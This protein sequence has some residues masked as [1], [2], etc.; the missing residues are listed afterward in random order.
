M[1][2][3]I[4]SWKGSGKGE[5]IVACRREINQFVSS[6]SYSDEL[7]WTD[8][9]VFVRVVSAVAVAMGKKR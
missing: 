9:L 3:K 4:V 6:S 5:L 2:V 8:R 1:L 7:K